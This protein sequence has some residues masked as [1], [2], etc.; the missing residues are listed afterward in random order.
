M[1]RSSLISI[2]GIVQSDDAVEVKSVARIEAYPDLVNA[3]RTTFI[4]ELIDAE[5]AQLAV[6]PLYCLHAHGHRPCCGGSGRA[7]EG[8]PSPPYLFQA[9]LPN[10]APG[11]ALRIR[12]GDKEIW[13]RQAPAEQPSIG[14]FGAFLREATLEIE[15]EVKGAAE[16]EPD[17]WAQW[18]PDEGKT[19]HGLTVGPQGEKSY[20]R[21][22]DSSGWACI[23]APS[24][25]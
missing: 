17:L 19:W 4:A 8:P 7:E 1:S 2:V 21:F 9:F 14:G 15:W 18:S 24:C 5:G 3:E 20:Y 12:Q 13:S 23:A 16:Q 10:V 25:S 11:A 22:R 6:G